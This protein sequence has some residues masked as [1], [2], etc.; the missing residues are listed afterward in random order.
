MVA[1]PLKEKLMERVEQPL[2]FFSVTYFLKCYRMV[3]TDSL[4]RDS[5]TKKDVLCCPIGKGPRMVFS[6]VS[7]LRSKTICRGSM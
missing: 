3:A 2:S 1:G 7:L 4:N 5:V 6:I